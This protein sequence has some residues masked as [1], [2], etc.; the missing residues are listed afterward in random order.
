VS[1]AADPRITAV[2]VIS[3]TDDAEEVLIGRRSP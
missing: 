3:P 2:A 1:A